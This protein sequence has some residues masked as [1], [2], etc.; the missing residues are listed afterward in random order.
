MPDGRQQHLPLCI[1]HDAGGSPGHQGKSHLFLQRLHHVTDA[2][3][4]V[5]QLLRRLGEA[6]QL[7][8]ADKRLIFLDVHV[9]SSGGQVIPL[10]HIRSYKLDILK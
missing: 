6:S 9:P 1:G 8:R 2:G 3:L 10:P 5:A 7:H 4:G